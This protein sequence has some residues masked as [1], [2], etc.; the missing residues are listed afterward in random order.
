MNCRPSNVEAL[1]SGLLY[2]QEV[3]HICDN[4]AKY[5]VFFILIKPSQL[6]DS[7]K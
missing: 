6:R 3:A 2:L 7:G 5:K 1:D 4:I